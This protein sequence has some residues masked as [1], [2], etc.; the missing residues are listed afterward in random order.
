MA[1]G[2][3]YLEEEARRLYVGLCM[4]SKGGNGDYSC[5]KYLQIYKHELTQRGEEDTEEAEM[6]L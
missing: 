2:A 6:R 4:W 1:G 5:C 3:K